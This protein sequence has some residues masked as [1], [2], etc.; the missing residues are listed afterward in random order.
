[1]LKCIFLLQ[2]YAVPKS[3]IFC[4]SQVEMFLA[5]YLVQVLVLL[6]PLNL[7]RVLGL[8]LVVKAVLNNR[9]A[10]YC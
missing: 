2:R 5:D 10:A 1:L 6:L 7:F 8:L 4:S 3:S 9:M